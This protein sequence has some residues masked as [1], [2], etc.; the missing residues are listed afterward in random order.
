MKQ[1][2]K[3]QDYS[4]VHQG[5]NFIIFFNVFVLNQVSSCTL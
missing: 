5:F 4:Q 3:T 1:N 2:N